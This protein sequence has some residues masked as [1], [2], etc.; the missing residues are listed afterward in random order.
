[1]P[2][3][4]VKQ[5]PGVLLLTNV[6]TP[7][8]F[9]VF[10]SLTEQVDL[11]VC[12]C[13]G[14]DPARVW[15]ARPQSE[16]VHY[17]ML[18]ASTLP[19][20]GGIEIVWNPGLWARLR[21][22][23][24]DVYIAG[25]NFTNLLSVLTL[26]RAARHWKKPF[27]LWSEAI[28]SAYAS[29]NWVSNLYRRWLYPRTDAFIAYGER[30]KAF[31]TRRGASP[32]RIVLGLQ[33][34]P[35]EQLPAP[36]VDKAGLGLE[37]KTVVLSVCYLT[38]RK[39]VKYLVSAFQA[40]AGEKDVL[41]LVGSGPEEAV[42]RQ[43]SQGDS[44]IMFPGYF[45][46]AEKSS[47]YAAADLFVL[48]TLHDPWGI[49]VNEAMAFGLPIITTESAGCVPDIVKDQENG[50]VV[51]AG[52]ENA[53]SA[54]LARLSKDADLRRQMG[55]HSRAIIADYTTEAARD[56]FLLVIEQALGYRLK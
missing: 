39:G 42:L 12:F 1:M 10:E 15:R 23:P 48:P 8:R 26:W 14:Y 21:R 18:A 7:T 28:D 53:L 27:A 45:D 2:K 5:R 25:E 40:I 30:A 36:A 56:R 43:M 22:D 41:A 32:E 35:P 3:A 16:R 17:E 24:F 31:L 49:V 9:P 33:V 11:T 20:P 46:G 29:G 55:Q 19:L 38:P 52:D 54:A 50:F 6:P 44:R 37:G 47:W 4:I 13:Q 34:I 51:P